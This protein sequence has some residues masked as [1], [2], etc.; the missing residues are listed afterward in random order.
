MGVFYNTLQSFFIQST[1]QPLPGQSHP[2]TPLKF[3]SPTLTS[4]V[5]PRPVYSIAY[6]TSALGCLKDKLI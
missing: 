3:M 6:S 4:L 1:L 2:L 5:S